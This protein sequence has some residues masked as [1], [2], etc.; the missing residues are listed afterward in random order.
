MTILARVHVIW[1]RNNSSMGAA[2]GRP[3]VGYCPCC[4]QGR[5]FSQWRFA[6]QWALLH[7]ADNHPA[8]NLTDSSISD[9]HAP[10]GLTPTG[11]DQAADDLAAYRA[12]LALVEELGC[13]RCVGGFIPAGR[14][15]IL[16]LVYTACP[17]CGEACR[18]C[19]STGLFPADTTCTEC[20]DEALTELGYTARFC[21]SCAGVTRINPSHEVTT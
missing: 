15:L 10:I 18:C 21:H 4:Q 5:F 16:G 9:T 13:E 14:H 8:D 2:I 7:A 17:D 3:W 20:L 11:L 6:H 19:N 12:E 1:D